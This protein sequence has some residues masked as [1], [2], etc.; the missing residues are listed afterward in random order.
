[1]NYQHHQ[2]TIIAC[3]KDIIFMTYQHRPHD[4][5][6]PLYFYPGLVANRDTITGDSGPILF[7]YY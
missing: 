4:L 6:T 2:L 5:S 3:P 7:G 1:M